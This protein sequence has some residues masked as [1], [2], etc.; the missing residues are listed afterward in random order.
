MASDNGLLPDLLIWELE[1][2]DRTLLAVSC[3]LFGG[4]WGQEEISR[5]TG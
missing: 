5:Y 1:N 4:T 3:A 2:W